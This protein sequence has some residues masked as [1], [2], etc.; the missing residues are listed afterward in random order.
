[1]QVLFLGIRRLLVE[2]GAGE[3]DAGLELLL[4]PLSGVRRDPDAVTSVLAAGS[5]AAAGAADPASPV[6]SSVASSPLE[7]PAASMTNVRAAQIVMIWTVGYPFRT[8]N[9]MPGR[10]QV[11]GCLSSSTEA[12]RSGFPPPMSL[13]EPLHILAS[14][15]SPQGTPTQRRSPVPEA[16]SG[17]R[18]DGTRPKPC[19]SGRPS[20]VSPCAA[21]SAA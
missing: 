9:R 12:P 15:K 13:S 21:T 11:G 14:G 10:L 2:H 20:T 6:P 19:E 3:D 1:M 18:R 4:D 17:F 8:S 5:A 7:Q 16:S